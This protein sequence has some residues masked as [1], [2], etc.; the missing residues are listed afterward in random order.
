MPDWHLAKERKTTGWELR[1]EFIHTHG[2]VLHALGI[3]GA[4]LLASD[5]K[6]W[7]KRLKRKIISQKMKEF[8]S[9]NLFQKLIVKI[10]N[11]KNCIPRIKNENY[12]YYNPSLCIIVFHSKIKSWTK[13]L[14][15]YP[16][17]R[18]DR[19]I[20]ISRFFIYFLIIL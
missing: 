15:R 20:T 1:Q 3:T 18:Q 6:G 5:S 7:K 13:G 19:V 8:E 16:F 12:K 2:I 4:Y 10:R 9:I 17:L 11:I 14:I